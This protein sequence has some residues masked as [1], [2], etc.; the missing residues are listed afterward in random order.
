MD[1]SQIRNYSSQINS[2][3]K[4]H[5]I[6]RVYLFGSVAR[7]QSTPESDVDFLVEMQEGASLFGMTGFEYEIEKLLNIPVDV[8]PISVLS[9]LQDQEFARRIQREAVAL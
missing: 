4:N 1:F 7:G 8:V 2:I 5:G 9:E 6:S 3:A